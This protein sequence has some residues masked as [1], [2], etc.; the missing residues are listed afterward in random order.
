MVALPLSVGVLLLVSAV[1][2][3][4]LDARRVCRR[5]PA[6][7]VETVLQRTPY[8][9]AVLPLVATPVIANVFFRFNDAALWN[10]PVCLQYHLSGIHWAVAGVSFA[11]LSAFAATVAYTTGHSERHKLPVAGIIV[12]GLVQYAQFV[13]TRPIAPRL[14]E[15]ISPDG[16]VLQTSGAS[17]V[18]ASAANIVRLLGGSATERQM[19]ELLGSAD[20]TSPAQVVYGLRPLGLQCELSRL[21]DADPSRL[22]P[23][24]MLLVDHPATGYAS[25]A[26]VYAAARA[27]RFEILDPLLGKRLL[28]RDQLLARWHGHAIFCAPSAIRRRSPSGTGARST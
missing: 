20:G 5:F 21:E 23:T 13:H 6:A 1:A 8:L 11:Y 4:A 12:V 9:W 2:L 28:T 25:H 3:A 14:T 24:T 22:K 18:P 17:C 27:D 26:V 16:V 7:T 15:R 10:L 19:A